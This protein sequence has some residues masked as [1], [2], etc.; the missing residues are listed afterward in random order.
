M[1]EGHDYSIHS[2][3]PSGRSRMYAFLAVITAFLAPLAQHW[4]MVFLRRYWGDDLDVDKAALF[5]GGFTALF[6]YGVLLNVFNGY[7]WRTSLGARMFR[8]IGLSAPPDLNG[9]YRG[10]LEWNSATDS[11]AAFHGDFFMRVSQTWEQIS[12][13]VQRR[14]EAG[15]LVL[16]HSDMATIRVGMMAGVNTLRFLYTFEESLPRTDGAGSMARQFSGAATCEFRRDGGAWHVTGHF[17]D[18]IGR[19]GQL[20][21]TQGRAGAGDAAPAPPAAAPSEQLPA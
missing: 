5:F 9:E 4:V 20:V 18:D 12:L 2:N 15:G 10:T 1:I 14:A 21:L 19:S 8:L 11:G 16:I 17:F 13:L 6:L 3:G 7:L